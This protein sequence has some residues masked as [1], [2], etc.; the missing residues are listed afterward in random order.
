[1]TR[2]IDPEQIQAVMNSLLEAVQREG[3][4]MTPDARLAP[5]DAA[6][7]L[8]LSPRTLK[9]ARSDAHDQRGP[10][11]RRLPGP[12]GGR[13]SYALTDLAQWMAAR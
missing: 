6:K 2:H 1:M 10:A 4:P 8:G 9:N 11:F 13:V 12:K 3:L 5:D 7:L